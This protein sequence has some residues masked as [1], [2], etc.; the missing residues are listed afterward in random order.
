MKK[1]NAPNSLLPFYLAHQLQINNNKN[2]YNLCFSYNLTEEDRTTLLIEKL[3][4]L[5]KSKPYL[6]QTFK[7]EEDKLIARIHSSLPATI[8]FFTSTL[9]DFDSLEKKLIREPHKLESNSSI[10]LNIIKI[11]DNNSYIALFN[12]HHIIMD[13]HSLEQFIADLNQ[14]IAGKSI[15]Q[16]NADDYI[17]RLKNEHLLND[18]NHPEIAKYLHTIHDIA[19]NMEYFDDKDRADVWYYT[20]DLP[21]STKQRLI[22][23]SKQYEISIF[24]LLL[25]A[26]SLFISKLSQQKNILVNYPVNT[27]SD[28]L[29]HGCFINMMVL[30]V[31]IREEDSYLTLIQHFRKRLP[32]LKFLTK[33]ELRNHLKYGPISSFANSNIA[34]PDD[35]VID[36]KSFK[37]KAYHQIANS[38]L[39]IKYKEDE[40]SLVFSVDI[41]STM[42]PECF[43]STLLP[44]FFNYCEKLLDNPLQ[45]LSKFDLTFTRER[46]QVL[47]EFNQTTQ[48]IPEDKTLVDLFEEQVQRTPERI[49]LVFEDIRLTYK[50]LNKKANQLAH[51]LTNHHQVKPDD[52][53]AL[54]L[55]RNEHT[56]IAILAVLKAGGAYI[57]LDLSYP[58]ERIEYI[59]DETQAKMVLVN[60]V[61]LNKLI[62]TVVHKDC[63][64]QSMLNKIDI[65]PIDSKKVQ[66]EFLELDISN[67]ITADTSANLAYVIYTSGTTGKPKG[68]MVEHKS[69]INTLWALKQVYK[70]R[71]VNPEVPLKITA[72]T[73]YAF[74]VSVS[75]F[76]VPL[77]HGDELH[78]LSNTLR[79]DILATSKYIND[80]QINYVYLPPVLLANLPR[81]KYPSLEA[82]IY[83]GEPCDSQTAHYWSNKTKLY[84]YY[85]PT[86]T[87][88]YATGLQIEVD[89]VN[90]IGK[91]IANTT[92]YVLSQEMMPQPIGIIGELYIGGHGLA[93]GY[94]HQREL[95][96]ERFITNPFQTD[97]EKIQ[98]I[99]ARLYKTGDLVRWCPDGNL[100][101]IGRNDFQIKIRGYRIELGEIESVLN[102]YPDIKQAIVLVRNL[103]DSED[104]LTSHK[105]LVGYYIADEKISEHKIH[106]YLALQLPDYMQP[107]ALVHLSQFPVTP[108]GKLDRAALPTPELTL[109]SN[110]IPPTNDKETLVCNAFSKILALP[111]VGIEDDFFKLGGNSISAISLVADLQANF[112]VNVMDIFNL[113]TPRKIVQDIPFIKDNLRKNLEKI[114][115]DYELRS[116]IFYDEQPFQ[117]KLDGYFQSIRQLE[118][119]R[120]KAP[121]SNILLTGATG[122]LGCNILKTLLMETEYS[123]FLLVRA[124]SDEEAF[125]RV[126]K[127]FE[128]YFEQNLHQI[129]NK[130]L[131]VYAGDIEKKDLGVSKETYQTLV[132]QIDSII[133]S[134]ALTKHYGEY[135]IFYLANVQATNHLLELSLLTKLKYFHYISTISVLNEGYIP[136]CDYYVFTED[137]AGDNLEER[138]NIYVKTKYEG[139]KVV[140]K[141]RKQG[142]KGNIYRVGN[143]AFNVSNY[144][145]QENI[146]EN[147][148]F[149]RL[150][151]LIDLKMV[152]PEISLEEISPVDL[153]AQAIVKLFDNENLSNST[154]HVFNPTPWNFGEFLTQDETFN[155]KMVPINQF[156]TTIINELDNPKYHHSIELFLLHRR[157]LNEQHHYSTHIRIQQDRTDAILKQMGFEWTPIINEAISKYLKREIER[158]RQSK[159]S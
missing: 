55:E 117:S 69:V 159:Y 136:N 3:Q 63:I 56:I 27:R 65:I 149:T 82:I 88:I 137:D 120:N 110:Y 92:A 40:D 147:G 68:V 36:G 111:K 15:T 11:S 119:N 116:T 54:L 75:E 32:F 122:F 53:I 84:N 152:A 142:V 108:N 19:G 37:S 150:C 103:I 100:E 78:L 44:R 134:A 118:I 146:D 104:G 124:N 51:Y 33:F 13:G 158:A 123:I 114:R 48:I 43:A 22:T 77:L 71:S 47:S 61:H 83:A 128:F 85:G 96:N 153:T 62:P 148:F 113:K 57:P 115:S 91:P 39:S 42:F 143:L 130:R 2:R 133:H 20:R 5:I 131:F 139:E 86:E 17:S 1:Y 97:D 72:F 4:E 46:K 26:W 94:L 23:A 49:A 67:I 90:L 10:Q 14:L 30:P 135:D 74:D 9:A 52:L 16:E 141:F 154:F 155:V 138:S 87:S 81:I 127:K 64:Y 101:Y 106:E 109:F 98:S 59:L 95:T 24:N 38:N 156:I 29:I 129:Y 121:I 89:E 25:L 50:E 132:T 31:S 125:E 76:F 80:N 8:Q 66:N 102:G 7:L 21:D 34:K 60:E 70:R 126:N 151:C 140:M 58:L 35:L 73:S 157:W 112:N 6:R 18:I 105:Y 144:Q 28:K 107:S 99:N 12:I 79:K 41:V 93:K 45:L 145:A